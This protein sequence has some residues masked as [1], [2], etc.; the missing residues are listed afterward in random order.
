VPINAHKSEAVRKACE[1]LYKELKQSG[2][3]VL[4][5]DIEKGRLGAMLADVELMG[6]PHR[7][8]VGDRGLENNTV[9]YKGRR[10]AESI[11]VPLVQINDFLMGKT[12]PAV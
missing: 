10:D 3:D 12:T 7:L 11:E 8:V 2:Y 6:I 4:L 1:D 9:E 5:M